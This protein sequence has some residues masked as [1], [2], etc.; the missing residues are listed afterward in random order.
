MFTRIG[1]KIKGFAKFT[2]WVGIIGSVILGFAVG[3]TSYSP[4]GLLVALIGSLLSWIGSFTLY[5]FGELIDTAMRIEDI[6][7][8]TD[9]IGQKKE[10]PSIWYCTSC[11]QQNTNNSSQCKN[12][13]KHRE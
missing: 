10:M 5:G 7:I 13:G 12:C 9:G 8:R 2:C 4:L 11:G 3:A 1:S 6:L